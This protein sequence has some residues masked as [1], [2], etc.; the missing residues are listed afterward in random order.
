MRFIIWFPWSPYSRW[1]AKREGRLDGGVSTDHNLYEARLLNFGEQEAGRIAQEWEDMDKR[2][3]SE[4]CTTKARCVVTQEELRSA[5][6]EMRKASQEYE[7]ARKKL[8]EILGRHHMKKPVYILLMLFLALAEFPLNA[9]AFRTTGEPEV[10]T[11]IMTGTLAVALPLCAH[12]LG[13]FLRFQKHTKREYALI[14]LNILLPVGAIAGVAYFRDKYIG[15]MQKVLGIE[16]DAT[17]VALIFVAIN[18]VIYLVAVLVSCLI[19]SLAVESGS[20]PEE[21]GGHVKT[22][23]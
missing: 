13:V 7:P 4:Y 19:S 21:G 22:R 2:L 20:S 9:I 14:I 8:E 16:M 1:R 6:E 3:K 5:K 17:T 23:V 10:T 18:L 15:E 12:F 11:Y